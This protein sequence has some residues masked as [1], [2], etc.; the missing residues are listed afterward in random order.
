M[1]SP[2]AAS[3]Y[4]LDVLMRNLKSTTLVFDSSR[5]PSIGDTSKDTLV[6]VKLFVFV[7]W[8]L[9]EQCVVELL[10]RCVKFV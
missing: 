3:D 8:V 10:E 4:D 2:P 6:S 1:S 5:S 7:T 9:E